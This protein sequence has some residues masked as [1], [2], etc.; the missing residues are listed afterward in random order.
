MAQWSMPVSRGWKLRVVAGKSAGNEYDL[1]PGRHLI[2]SGRQATIQV[3]DPSV[4]EE[5]LELDVQTG[6]VLLT[7]RSGRPNGLLVNGKP[8]RQHQAQVGD[9]VQTGVFRFQLINAGLAAAKPAPA[10]NWVESQATSLMARLGK[11]ET[12]W[13]VA[14]VSGTLAGLLLLLMALT[15]N[16]I[17]AP[18]TVLAVSIVAPA[19]VIAYLVE[20][21][22]K[23]G[24]SL[25]T[26]A[27]TFIFGGTIGFVVTIVAGSLAGAV[28]GGLIL[29][30]VFAGVFEEPAKLIATA[31]RWRHPTYDRP[32][33]GL[34]LGAVSGFGFAVFETAGYFL[35]VMLSD[36]LQSSIVVVFVRSLSAPFT[37][38]LWSAII[39]AAF[40]QAGRRPQTAIKDKRFLIAL[41]TGVGL[42]ALW[43]LGAGLGCAAPFILCGV[44]YLSLWQF[45]LRLQ[46]KGYMQ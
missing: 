25:R 14:L 26:L 11:L 16:P 23:T 42:H 28:T 37:H 27:L 13:Q 45:R 22:D 12:H 29:L 36:G 43:N 9:E 38:G 8:A 17:M 6:H 35:T 5:H 34:I 24:I 3:P 18:V 33:D 40:W 30:P 10:D 7:D 41:G 4:A 2:G 31:W 32:M 20:R 46:N 1:K 39:G 21:F 19:T 44:A 15:S